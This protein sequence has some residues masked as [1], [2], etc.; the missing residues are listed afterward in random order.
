MLALH[1]IT[2]LLFI[3]AL[4]YYLMTNMQWY[5]YKIERVMFHHTK[6]WWHFAYFLIPYSLY[7]LAGAY[8]FVVVVGY[9]VLLYDW[10]RRLDKPLVLT[11]RV[12]RFFVALLFFG[13]F[14]DL[15]CVVL[16]N[17]ANFATMIPLFL[18]FIVSGALEAI[19]FSGFKNQAKKKLQTHTNM[20]IVG[21][22]A[23]YGKTSIKNFLAHI[24]KARY[25][26]YATPRSVNTLGGVLKD[27]N[28]DLPSDTEVYIV[29]MGARGEGDIW[30]IT[31]FVEPHYAIVGKIGS[32][33]LEYFGSLKKIRNTK[34][35]LTQ[36]PRLKEAW[37][38]SSAHINPSEIIHQF[39]APLDVKATLEGIDFTLDDTLYHANILGGF[40]AQNIALAI[41]V[42]KALGLS[43]EQIQTQV[44]TI[45]P[46]QNRLQ[47]INAGG[48]I[49]LDD[50]FNGNIDGMLASF[51]LA[52]THTGRKV[53]IT[54]GLVEV[55]KHFNETVAQQANAIFDVIVVT[56]DL[57]YPIFKDFIEPQKLLKL[58]S[59]D[60]MQ[61]MLIEQTRVGD[62]I[63]FANDAP[64]FI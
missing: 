48:K 64:S 51:E 50:S 12:K 43:N 11:G 54:P 26:T 7:L 30:E 31:E 45:K 6:A 40:N 21:I 49:I 13:F 44:S 61:E 36:S 25:K 33:H 63:L 15:M 62:L 8:G 9:G 23:S 56:S 55:D 60:K 41:E 35:E 52:A 38:D 58:S 59:K 47:R 37:V 53:L 16:G 29:E 32:A 46:V 39:N 19:L 18:A 17:C 5:S 20:I 14:E 1:F 27:I 4:G 24:L 22:T 10:Y 3:L 34:M 2:H 57:N 42:A 28:E